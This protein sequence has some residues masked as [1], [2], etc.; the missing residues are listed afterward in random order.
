[1]ALSAA[2][3]VLNRHAHLTADASLQFAVANASL[4][5]GLA[6]GARQE[7]DRALDALDRVQEIWTFTPYTANHIQAAYTQALALTSLAFIP[8]KQEGHKGLGRQ[9]REGGKA[10]SPLGSFVGNEGRNLARL[11]TPSDFKVGM[12]ALEKAVAILER[13]AYYDR[14]NPTLSQKCAGDLFKAY[15]T[16]AEIHAITGVMSVIKGESGGEEHHAAAIQAVDR[17]RELAGGEGAGTITQTEKFLGEARLKAATIRML[18]FLTG[19]ASQDME[20][21]FLKDVGR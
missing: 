6:T 9:E 21:F 3:G 18:M 8:S 5:V 7:V 14:T 11:P 12:E 19:K 17:A 13:I 4:T 1:M 15:I 10:D 16:L 2:L 20:E